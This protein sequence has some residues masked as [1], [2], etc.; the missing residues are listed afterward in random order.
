MKSTSSQIQE[1]IKQPFRLSNI[2]DLVEKESGEV[3]TW[4]ALLYK[5][6]KPT[7]FFIEHV[8]NQGERKVYVVTK[9]NWCALYA[10][11]SGQDLEFYRFKNLFRTLV[12][13]PPIQTEQDGTLIFAT[14]KNWYKIVIISLFTI[15]L[16]WYL[17]SGIKG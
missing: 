10:L 6:L 2:E 7:M 15:R 8:P 9:E 17:I 5:G 14:R 1:I 12:C 3:T 16:G 4:P 11:L 13:E